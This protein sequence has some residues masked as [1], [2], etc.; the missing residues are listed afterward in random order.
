[1][2]DVSKSAV[3]ARTGGGLPDYGRKQA[4]GSLR[5]KTE[6][7]NVP[8]SHRCLLVGTLVR[9]APGVLAPTRPDVLLDLIRS[10]ALALSEVLLF[11]LLDLGEACR[12]P[13]PEA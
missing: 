8:C 1:M 11:V 7:D 10:F 3:G 12:C 5:T 9:G 6:P 2:D 13:V 4:E